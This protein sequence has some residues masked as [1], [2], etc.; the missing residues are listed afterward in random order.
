MREWNWQRKIILKELSQMRLKKNIRTKEQ[1]TR[2]IK[3]E[4]WRYTRN[5]AQKLHEL[6][7]ADLKWARR[8]MIATKILTTKRKQ[9]EEFA[10]LLEE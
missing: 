7:A 3:R 1:K 9:L 5:S 8:D 4:N 6:P 2:S 10:K